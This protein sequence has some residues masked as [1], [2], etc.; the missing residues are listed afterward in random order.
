MRADGRVEWIPPPQLDNGQA[1]VNDFHHPQNYL[2]RDG[3]TNR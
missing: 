2:L 3:E 1:R